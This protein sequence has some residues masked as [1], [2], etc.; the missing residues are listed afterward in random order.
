[1]LISQ[2]G[3]Y[4]LIMVSLESIK[5]NQRCSIL[6]DGNNVN[7]EVHSTSPMLGTGTYTGKVYYW[8]GVDDKC[9]TVPFGF[10]FSSYAVNTMWNLWIFGNSVQEIC[11]YHNIS[12]EHDLVKTTCKIRRCRTKKV[13][14]Y[15]IKVA[16]AG[17]YMSCLRDLKDII[18][19]QRVYDYAYPKLIQTLYTINKMPNRPNDL[20]INT[21]A[22]RMIKKKLLYD[23]VV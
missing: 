12:A 20:N 23:D 13:I 2:D 7:T 3:P 6:S 21:V 4:G 22:N 19:S 8:T 14:N 15:L 18:Q 16:I 5:S 10:E 17:N 1:M 11:P 9:H